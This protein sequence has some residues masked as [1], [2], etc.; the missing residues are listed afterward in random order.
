MVFRIRIQ[1]DLD[2]G[3]SKPDEESEEFL[4]EETHVIKS[5]EVLQ[6]SK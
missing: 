1:L 2:A 4:L 5:L 3:R 6:F